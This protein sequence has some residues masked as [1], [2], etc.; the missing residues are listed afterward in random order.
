MIRSRT[1]INGFEKR[2]F[3][4]LVIA[5]FI[6]VALYGYFISMSIVH[7]LVREEVENSIASISSAIGEF[8]S[9]YIV[10]KEAITI[11]NAY[12]LG[13]KNLR[14]KTFVERRTSQGGRLTFNEN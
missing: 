12:S 2:A 7:V 10:N 4:L 6:L 14:K 3:S 5:I 11:E 9:Q 8:E 1:A 13:F